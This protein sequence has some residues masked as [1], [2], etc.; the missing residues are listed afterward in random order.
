MVF[1]GRKYANE[2]QD[3][4]DDLIDEGAGVKDIRVPSDDYEEVLVES[5][6]D[7]GD[8]VRAY[9]TDW[10]PGKKSAK[11]KYKDGY[12]GNGWKFDSACKHS[13]K[14]IPKKVDFEF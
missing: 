11:I 10:Q 8:W 3:L 7:A 5:R 2:I 9:V 13:I 6:L 1:E 4:L 12:P 14:R